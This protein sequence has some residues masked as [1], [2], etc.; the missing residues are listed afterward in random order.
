[1]VLSSH[2]R[3]NQS[4]RECGWLLS[5]NGTLLFTLLSP[6]TLSFDILSKVNRI[7]MTVKAFPVTYKNESRGTWSTLGAARRRKPAGW[8]YVLE[9]QKSR[10]RE[11]PISNF[12]SGGGGSILP[13]SPPRRMCCFTKRYDC[14]SSILHFSHPFSSDRSYAFYISNNNL[15]TPIMGCTLRQSANAELTPT[16]FPSKHYLSHWSVQHLP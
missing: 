2:V 1:M 7:I 10:L 9:Y 15:S 13:H 3:Q 8:N 11:F 5:L 16:P 14:C 4:R 12:S 6:F